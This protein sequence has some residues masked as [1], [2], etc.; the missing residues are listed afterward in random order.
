MY[1]ESR[2]RL[3][4]ETTLVLQPVTQLQYYLTVHLVFVMAVTNLNIL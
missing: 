2:D 3:V 4:H 1:I